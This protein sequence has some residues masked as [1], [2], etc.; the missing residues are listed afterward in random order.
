MDVIRIV[1]VKD[2]G[3]AIRTMISILL[4]EMY[5]VCIKQEY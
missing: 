4:L 5:S 1:V 2:Q 3:K